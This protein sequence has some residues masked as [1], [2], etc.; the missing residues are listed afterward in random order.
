[1]E[2]RSGRLLES[3]KF[4]DSRPR[5]RC[6]TSY[7][8][9]PL[10][11]DCLLL[12]FQ[13]MEHTPTT[14]CTLRLVCRR[15]TRLVEAACVWKTIVLDR[16]QLGTQYQK[17]MGSRLVQIH[18][19]HVQRLTLRS[20]IKHYALNFAS[21][22]IFSS[23]TCLNTS[24]MSFPEIQSLL[25]QLHNLEV[26]NCQQVRHHCDGPNFSLERFSHLRRLREL[27]LC[28]AGISGFDHHKYYNVYGPPRWL[29][30]TLKVL[31]IKHLIDEEELEY[32]DPAKDELDWLARETRVVA[33][34]RYLSQLPNITSLTFGFCSSW[35]ARVWSECLHGSCPLLEDLHLI[36]WSGD[37]THMEWSDR[38]KTVWL[39]AERSM[40][41]WLKQLTSLKR[42]ELTNFFAGY[43]VI[44]GIKDLDIDSLT[45]TFQTDVSHMLKDWTSGKLGG[46]LEDLITS[47]FGGHQTKHPR[48]LT[49]VLPVYSDMRSREWAKE[50]KR[51]ALQEV[52]Y[53]I[54]IRIHFTGILMFDTQ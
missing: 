17:F 33:K 46:K 24:N 3:R 19:Q 4:V 10:N 40:S 15:W 50:I 18:R 23:L 34:Y 25:S 26:I 12:I 43:G 44:N 14:L 41:T 35:S 49:I 31:S 52:K 36:G 8:N 30:P 21:L 28:H 16:Q 20:A 45:V 47:A 27:R 42:L 48:T 29:S 37:K 7:S 11:D 5:K 22:S 32:T 51:K 9:D 13:A 6:R 1:M 39:D 2:L 54:D 38:M 53:D